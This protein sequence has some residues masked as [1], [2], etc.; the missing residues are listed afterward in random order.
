IGS[1]YTATVTTPSPSCVTCE[2]DPACAAVANCPASSYHS[3]QVT[4]DEPNHPTT[5]AALFGQ[6]SWNVSRTAV[7]GLQFEPHYNLLA[8]SPNGGTSDIVLNCGFN[9]F[10]SCNIIVDYGELGTNAFVKTNCLFPCDYTI[11]PGY[12][13]INVSGGT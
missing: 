12:R 5:T 9:I 8:L 10:T 13:F 1:S 7:A 11:T 2:P 3:I 6:S 4:V